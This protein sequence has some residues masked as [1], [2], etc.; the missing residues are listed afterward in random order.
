MSNLHSPSQMPKPLPINNAIATRNVQQKL[1]FEDHSGILPT[2]NIISTSISSSNTGTS[3][4]EDSKLIFSPKKPAKKARTIIPMPCLDSRTVSI[5]P[6]YD[7]LTTKGATQTSLDAIANMPTT[8]TTTSKKNKDRRS[9]PTAPLWDRCPSLNKFARLLPSTKLVKSLVSKLEPS[10][11]LRP[12]V[13]TSLSPD[14]EFENTLKTPGFAP[15]KSHEFLCFSESLEPVKLSEH[16]PCSTTHSSSDTSIDSSPLRPSMM[17][18]YSTTSPFDIGQENPSS[19]SS[20]STKTPISIADTIVESFRPECQEFFALIDHLMNS[21]QMTHTALS[22]AVLQKKYKSPRLFIKLLME[23]N[24]INS[25]AYSSSLKL[26]NQLFLRSTMKTPTWT[27]SR[28]E[29]QRDWIA[30]G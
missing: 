1:D 28:Q 22:S 30:H 3:L 11:M 27:P 10:L 24:R 15:S 23:E 9:S 29:S 21:F 17:E 26:L 20:T 4:E 13:P 5:P 19:T 16:W 12:F 18:L 6:T 25:Q 14:P 2:P 8:P 7:F